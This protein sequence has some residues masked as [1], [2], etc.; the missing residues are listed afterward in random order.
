MENNNSQPTLSF[1]SKQFSTYLVIALMNSTTY[2]LE[3]IR[4]RMQTIP[5][6]IRQKRIST[7]YSSIFDCVSQIKKHE[8]IK[9]FWKGNFTNLLRMLPNESFN[10]FIKES[11]QI[12]AKK[13]QFASKNDA[14]IN[15]ISGSIG[16][17]FTL[18]FIYPLDFTRSRLSNE[19]GGKGSIRKILSNVYKA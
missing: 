10:F 11:F 14:S 15:F 1:I 3:M 9:A 7:P 18:I 17:I 4:T 2:P 19:V 8:G 5:E 6:L 12:W 13:H 16:A